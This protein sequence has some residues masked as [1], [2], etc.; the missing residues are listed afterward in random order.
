M[1]PTPRRR[2]VRPG[3]TDPQAFYQLP[4][5]E[6]S[7]REHPQ[8]PVVISEGDSWFAYPTFLAPSIVD[9]LLKW[10]RGASWLRCETIGDEV[11]LML[12]HD[13]R[14]QLATRLERYP[15]DVLLFSGGGND[16]VGQPFTLWLKD[17]EPGFTRATDYID[18]P[19]AKAM[20]KLV[21]SAYEDLLELRDKHRPDCL[22]VTH[23]YDLPTPSEVGVC[24]RGPWMLPG[25]KQR[26]VP[27]RFHAAIAKYFLGE[28]A[29][30]LDTLA[31]RRN[32]HVVQTQGTLAGP[33]EWGNEIHPTARGFAR[34]AKRIQNDL[35]ALKPEQFTPRP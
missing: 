24:G 32:F 16:I 19:R 9:N 34:I 7:I 4:Q 5:F 8:R 29:A 18:Q 13:Q 27:T 17:H 6:K 33:S 31:R 23:N 21:R 28:F 11:R 26:G 22:I 25:L 12:G 1:P 30:M 10:N 20:L 3:R 15:V 35:A 14:E 2:R